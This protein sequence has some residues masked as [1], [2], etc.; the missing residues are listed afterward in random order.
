MILPSEALATQQLVC[1]RLDSKCSACTLPLTPGHTFQWHQ[2]QLS[3]QVYRYALCVTV[4][5]WTHDRLFGMYWQRWGISVAMPGFHTL[6][7]AGFCWILKSSEWIRSDLGHRKMNFIIRLTLACNLANWPNMWGLL[8][9]EEKWRYV[10]VCWSTSNWN[11]TKCYRPSNE[12]IKK[13]YY[14]CLNN[15][16]FRLSWKQLNMS[17]VLWI[18]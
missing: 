15:V 5:H 18:T 3:V 4:G 10:R 8:I 14:I 13:W 9:R 17:P 2:L 6:H 7:E 12:T 11:M 16:K 1:C